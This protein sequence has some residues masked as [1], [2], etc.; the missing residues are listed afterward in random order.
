M[1]DRDRERLIGIHPTLATAISHVFDQMSA[2][3]F[4]MMIV[5][6]VRTLQVQ[7][8][9]Y[10]QGRTR[11]GDIVTMKDGVKFPSDHQVHADGFGHAVDCAFVGGDPFGASKPWE[12][13]GET[14]EA[15][16]LTW[17]GRWSHPHDSPH[18][19]LR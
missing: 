18:A 10:A 17:G 1:T 7:Q 13:F 8:A 14:V 12:R 3:G 19:E 4:P 2:L 6:G 9:L 15:Q 16:G 11:P 5:Q